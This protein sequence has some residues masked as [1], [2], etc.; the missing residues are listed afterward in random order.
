MAFCN[1]ILT[2]VTERDSYANTAKETEHQR[3]TIYTT[4]HFAR[5][6]YLLTTVRYI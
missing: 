5:Y 6:E 2:Q 3:R 1:H 4:G